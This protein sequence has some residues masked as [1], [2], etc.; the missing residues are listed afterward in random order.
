MS[1]EYAFRISGRLTPALSGALEPL[2]V[3]GATTETLL[4]GRVAD[5]A[6]LQGVIAHIAALGLELV[7]LRRLPPRPGDGKARV[8][9]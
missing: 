7:E 2:E 4:V 9:A 1:V 8:V 5:P 6:Q 3:T